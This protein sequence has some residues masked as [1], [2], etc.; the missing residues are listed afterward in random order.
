[1][2]KQHKGILETIIQRSITIECAKPNPMPLAERRVRELIRRGQADTLSGFARAF[3][4]QFERIKRWDCIDI[5]ERL[6]WV[7]MKRCVHQV[8]EMSHVSQASN[9]K[10]SRRRERL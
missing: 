6:H 2:I 10:P 1:M 3:P 8:G 7:P 9:I 4:R 5:D